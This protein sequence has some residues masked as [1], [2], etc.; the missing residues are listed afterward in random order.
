MFKG[1]EGLTWTECFDFC[2]LQGLGREKAGAIKSII[3]IFL[4]LLVMNF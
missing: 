2:F 4:Y 1:N 3:S